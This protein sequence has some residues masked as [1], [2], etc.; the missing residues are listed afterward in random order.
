MALSR[1][2]ASLLDDALDEALASSFPAATVLLYA[3]GGAPGP[4]ALAVASRPSVGTVYTTTPSNADCGLHAAA[5]KVVP[6]ASASATGG[7]LPIAN[8][9]L[10]VAVR[11]PIASRA[12][13]RQSEL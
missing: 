10:D 13:F 7:R 4:S 9:S 1:R 5:S 2:E 11:V 3:E 12:G 6:L 8:G